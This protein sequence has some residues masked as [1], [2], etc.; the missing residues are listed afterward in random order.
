MRISL[1]FSMPA[2]VLAFFLAL[3]LTLS[4]CRQQTV[5]PLRFSGKT[6]GTTWSAIVVAEGEVAATLKALPVQADFERILSRVND[7]MSTWQS[8]SELSNFNRQQSEDWFAVSP[9]LAEVVAAAQAV[10]ALS[11]GVYDTTVGPLVNLWGFGAQSDA[12]KVPVAA[13]IA[14]ALATVGYQK[15]AVR[16]EPP[17]LR[18]RV[19][20][21]S[22]DLSSIAKGYGVDQL[23]AYLDEAGV[24][25]YMVEIGGEIHSKGQSP[26][27][28][29][30][31]IAV[32]KPVALDRMVQQG[33]LLK[34]G[35]LAT[36]GD[37]RNYFTTNGRRYSHTFDPRSGAPVRHS[38]ASVSV[39]AANTMLADA[40]AT[41]LMAMGEIKGRAFALEQGI[42]AYFIWRTDEGFDTFATEGFKAVLISADE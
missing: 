42:E 37:Y 28:D 2:L 32:E 13:D 21:L 12:Q 33:L 30:W 29:D 31:R 22:V 16:A 5:E 6:M 19:V 9:A 35:G 41:M 39:L 4:A 18:K 23:A 20:G 14:A 26:R 34:G 7:Q 17:A 15:L 36:S 27:G 25:H 38:L 11:A 10:S 1:P 24:A 3:L 8:D 40:Y